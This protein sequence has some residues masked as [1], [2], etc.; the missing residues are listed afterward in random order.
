MPHLNVSPIFAHYNPLYD[1]SDLEIC[2]YIVDET[3]VHA[4]CVSSV[5]SPTISFSH[6]DILPAT[7]A[8]V[9]VDDCV[10]LPS[11]GQVMIFIDLCHDILINSFS[12][13]FICFFFGF[14][15]CNDK[16]FFMCLLAWAD[17]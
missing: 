12:F 8:H 16:P 1:S 15:S 3:Q 4:S 14:L 11:V 2:T 7:H 17:Y 5:E 13:P 10:A 6:L 9:K